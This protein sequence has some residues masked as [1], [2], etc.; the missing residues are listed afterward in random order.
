MAVNLRNVEAV[1]RNRSLFMDFNFVC[2]GE[3]E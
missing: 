3:A 2:G 1:V